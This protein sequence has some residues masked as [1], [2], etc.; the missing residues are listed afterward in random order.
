[1]QRRNA[2]SSNRGQDTRT[3]SIGLS[4]RDHNELLRTMHHLPQSRG[5]LGLCRNPTSVPT[6]H[7]LLRGALHLHPPTYLNS[8]HRDPHQQRHRPL[9]RRPRRHHRNHPQLDTHST[10]RTSG[11]RNPNPH[12][13]HRLFRRLLLR[14]ALT[15]NPIQP[16]DRPTNQHRLHLPLPLS[17]EPCHLHVPDRNDHDHVLHHRRRDRDDDLHDHDRDICSGHRGTSGDF[18]NGEYNRELH[19]IRHEPATS[20]LYR[21]R[22]VKLQDEVCGGIMA[23]ISG[24]GGGVI[25]ERAVSVEMGNLKNMHGGLCF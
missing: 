19:R 10:T 5:H 23:A 8:N 21:L 15:I 1:M 22:R 12:R 17:P 6:I 9:K 13:R 18:R 14:S 16:R 3:L 20:H 11:N 7:Q 4:I 2:R 25:G 24:V